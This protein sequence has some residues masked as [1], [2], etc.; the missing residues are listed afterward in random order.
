MTSLCVTFVL[1]SGKD[2]INCSL[3]AKQQQ[4]EANYSFVVE[5]TVCRSNYHSQYFIY[6]F[7]IDEKRLILRR[8]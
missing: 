2:Y 4:T 8:T 3:R 5:Q 7:Q 1:L 6:G